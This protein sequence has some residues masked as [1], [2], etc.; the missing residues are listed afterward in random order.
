MLSVST[1]SVKGKERIKT[2]SSLK[3]HGIYFR[4][5]RWK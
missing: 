3:P 1:K 4:V 2:N 5:Y